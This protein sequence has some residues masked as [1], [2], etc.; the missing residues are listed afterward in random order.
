MKNTTVISQVG[1]AFLTNRLLQILIAVLSVGNLLSNWKISLDDSW[2]GVNS[3]LF[4]PFFGVGS[5]F[6][7]YFP[8]V[9]I[10]FV[11]LITMQI[12]AK[13]QLSNVRF[14]SIIREGFKG[15]TKRMLSVTLATVIA[16]ILITDVFSIVLLVLKHGF[17][18]VVDPILISNGLDGIF[19]PIMTTLTLLFFQLLYAAGYTIGSLLL[20]QFVT[21]LWQ[22]IVYP[23]IWFVIF[24]QLVA[25][26]SIGLGYSSL[27]N[28]SPERITNRIM[29]A[30]PNETGWQAFNLNL[31][32]SVGMILIYGLALIAA[33]N[34]QRKRGGIL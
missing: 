7:P 5:T 12:N 11:I 33:W 10:L 15:Y 4:E 13:E 34:W 22:T 8:Y 23:F 14:W 9:M 2:G 1:D 24:P 19:G 30:Y 16:F 25:E 26:L 28:Y 31:G 3:I 18:F 21:R 17:I 20:M 32:L 29:I 6:G 27:A